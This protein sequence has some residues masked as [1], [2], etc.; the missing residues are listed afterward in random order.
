MTAET[1]DRA[2]SAVSMAFGVL[3][4]FHSASATGPV[5]R[6]AQRHL[7]AW[8]L[9]PIAAQI[10]AEA[11]VKFGAAVKLDVMRP[12]QAFDAGGRARAVSAIVLRS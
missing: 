6:E 8:T 2:R 12:L 4:A 9:A 11:S 1:L 7:A 3:P 5:I 10:A